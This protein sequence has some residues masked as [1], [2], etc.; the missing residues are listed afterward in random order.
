MVEQSNTSSMLFTEQLVNKGK[1]LILTPT[2]GQVKASFIW[3]HG[4]GLG[5]KLN[6][7]WFNY[8]Q[9]SDLKFHVPPGF[10]VV[11]PQGPF[12]I[13][14]TWNNNP[15]GEAW[16]AS[17]GPVKPAGNDATSVA[18]VLDHVN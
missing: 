2:S 8:S 18:L 14:S 1:T 13:N 7:G 15:E 4:L 6:A 16:Y 12:I 9:N 5:L 17:E 10:R 3:L 11:I